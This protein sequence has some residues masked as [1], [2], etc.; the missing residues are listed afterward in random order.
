MEVAGLEARMRNCKEVFRLEAS[1]HLHRA[2][3]WAGFRVQRS[4]EVTL[5]CSFVSSLKGQE[6]VK[7]DRST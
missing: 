5:N 6:K 7:A 4:R 3:D 1:I 2:S